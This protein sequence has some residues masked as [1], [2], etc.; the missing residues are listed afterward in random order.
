MLLLSTSGFKK[1]F[2]AAACLHARRHDRIDDRGEITAAH[3]D[4]QQVNE[5]SAPRHS[6]ERANAVRPFADGHAR[7]ARSTGAT[8]SRGRC[9]RVARLVSSRPMGPTGG[10]LDSRAFFLL[11]CGDSRS[12]PRTLAHRLPPLEPQALKRHDVPDLRRRATRE[13]R[14]R[15][16]HPRVEPPGASFAARTSHAHAC[17]KKRGGCFC[18]L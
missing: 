17:S 14:G 9:V 15:P 7:S 3:I 12:G 1:T 6:R 5:T 11:T 10:C 8:K 16:E 2:S 4:H 13:Q 18:R